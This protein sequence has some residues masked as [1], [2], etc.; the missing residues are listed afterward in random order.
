MNGLEQKKNFKK[1]KIQITDAE[2]LYAISEKGNSNEVSIP[3]EEIHKTK[4]TQHVAKQPWLI[5]GSALIL[6]A[7]L[8]LLVPEKSSFQT[9]TKL[10]MIIMGVVCFSIYYLTKEKYWKLQVASDSYLYIHKEIPNHNTVD[11]FIDTLFLSR[12]SY[13]HKEYGNINPNLP[14]ESQLNNFKFLK[15]LKVW[16][17]N[18]FQLKVE[19]LDKTFNRQTHI[20][21]FNTSQDN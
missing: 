14:Y 17:E 3:F 7:M 16:D 2:I 9:E 13:L 19:E 4:L 8:F 11:K 12:D 21:G 20:K 5:A 6:S 10:L 15:K 1:I 18:E